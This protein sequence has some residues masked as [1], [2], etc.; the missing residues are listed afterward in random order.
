MANVNAPFGFRP[1]RHITGGTPGRTNG[2][3]IASGYGTSIYYGDPVRSDGNGGIILATNAAAILGIFLGVNFTAPDGS[4]IFS[5][6]WTASQALKAGSKAMAL[7]CDDEMQLY[8]VMTAGSLSDAE[9]GLLVNVDFSTAGNDQ[10]GYSRAAVTGA[11]GSEN[12]FR[13]ERI[14][15]PVIRN[16]DG[17]SALSLPGQ[18]ATVEVS[19]ARSERGVSRVVPA[20]T[21]V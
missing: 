20:S 18:Y 12:Q 7:V 6:K 21:E 8:E 9:V 14:L 16:S 15:Q 1:T 11:A 10:S 17:M 4:I 3:S 13:V 2:F 19:L 5:P